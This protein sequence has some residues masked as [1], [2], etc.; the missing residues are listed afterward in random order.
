M[1][2]DIF[3]FINVMDLHFKYNLNDKGS[4]DAKIIFDIKNDV[5]YFDK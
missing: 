5:K 1:N 3:Y 4:Y 2:E